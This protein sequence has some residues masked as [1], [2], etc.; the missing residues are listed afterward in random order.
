M[1]PTL[2]CGLLVVGLGSGGCEAQPDSPLF[3][4]G[5]ARR[6]DGSP[7]GQTALSLEGA[8]RGTVADELPVF[9]PYGTATTRDNGA[10]VLEILAGDIAP[11]VAGELTWPRSTFRDRFRVATPLEEGRA[12]FVSFTL[13]GTGDSELPELRVWGADLAWSE[14]ATGRALTF[15]PPPPAPAP[16]QGVVV[17]ADDTT[18]YPGAPSGDL[19]D[20]SI[21]KPELQLHGK[22]GLVWHE[23]AVTSPRHLSPWLLEDFVTPEVQ[24]RAVSANAWHRDALTS[25]EAWLQFRIEWRS[26]RLPLPEGTLRPLSRGARCLPALDAPCPFTDGLL[27]EKRTSELWPLETSSYPRRVGVRLEAP[28]RISRVVIR[29]MVTSGKE[30]LVE[31]SEDGAQ[32][33]ELARRKLAE[34]F[35]SGVSRGFREA[36]DADSP[37]D[38]PLPRYD[39]TF[40]DIPLPESPQVQYVRLVCLS[41]PPYEA[42]VTSLAELSLFE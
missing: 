42:E 35:T 16:P 28:A 9:T 23:D 25:D 24:V 37:W 14:T 33:T 1:R 27:T 20:V 39:H 8:R 38:P 26:E 3:F 41:F 2:L 18:P 21:P 11:I 5:L 7:F 13:Y 12:A 31:G 32:W 4:Y 34:S 10:F 22:E 36:S 40:L 6:V 17:S 29:N 15:A 30:V 19:V